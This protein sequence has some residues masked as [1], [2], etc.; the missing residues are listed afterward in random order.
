M[1]YKKRN[2]ILHSKM[3]VLSGLVLAYSEVINGNHSPE[4]DLWP[5]KQEWVFLDITR[6]ALYFNFF[7]FYI[8]R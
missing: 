6:K 7:F 3:F 1:L 8:D 5:P 2:G 4:D